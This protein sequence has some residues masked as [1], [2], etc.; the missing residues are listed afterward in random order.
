[1][2]GA[3]LG[4]L[5]LAIL[6]VLRLTDPDRALPPSHVV[7]GLGA[8]A[9]VVALAASAAACWAPRWTQWVVL[10]GTCVLTAC[11]AAGLLSGTRWAVGALY[12]DSG[13]RTQTLTRYAADPSWADYGYRDLPAYYPPLVPWFEGRLAAALDVP[14]WTLLKP[15]TLA[16]SLVIPV[17]AFLLWRRVV[18]DL[19][20][21]LLVAATTVV[22]GDL[23]KPDEWLVLACLVPWWLE[24]V[25]GVRRPEARSI[26]RWVQGV[27]L[28]LLLLTHTVYVLPFILATLLGWGVDLAL[29][30]PAPL[31][32]RDTAVV[33]GTALFV[34]APY[35]LPAALPRLTGAPTD[36]L[37]LRWNP[38]G[39][40][41]PP[42]PWPDDP[43]GVLAVV[44]VAW[45]LWR[46]RSDRLAQAV[47][48]LLVG[49]YAVA[50][51]GQLLLQVDIAILPHKSHRLIGDVLAVAG[52]LAWV[53][54]GRLVLARVGRRRLAA[55][56]AL[57]AVGTAVAVPLV[58]SRAQYWA[59]SRFVQASRETRYPDGSY[60]AAL[61]ASGP[62]LEPWRGPWSVR[63]E[64]PPLTDILAAW[65]R[66]SGRSPEQDS[67]TVLLT[68]RGDLLGTTPVH[69]FIAWKSIYS[70]PNGQ[71]EE[72]FELLQRVGRCADSE[73][74]ARL[75]TDNPYDRVDGII[76]RQEYDGLAFPLG[77]D[78]F[79]EGW[80]YIVLRLPD[81]LFRGPYFEREVVGSIV[82]AS[83]RD[84]DGGER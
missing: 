70:H 62:S 64:D 29:R 82:V 5:A 43:V 21:A 71:F 41:E 44:G 40:D 24:V 9:A 56:L 68:V 7:T 65:R 12:S 2:L 49:G 39:F 38:R 50:L 69:N 45:L 46:L 37:Q 79:P 73:C 53:A 55:V 25:R 74:A 76:A 54:L 63:P 78:H 30:R 33:A 16:A 23:Q 47:A 8:G 60:P 51:G 77:I 57:G 20:A 22:G 14:A 28:G 67:E 27:V 34:S 61:P 59:E 15:A 72:R 81:R 52:V 42:G 83:V 6:L 4:G 75:L 31:G 35:W 36:N 84:P 17:L 11:M 48:M 26:P 32:L 80:D 10:A 18:P 19:V 1:M 66:V 3:A 13:F 58:I